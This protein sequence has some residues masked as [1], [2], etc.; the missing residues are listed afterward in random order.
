MAWFVPTDQLDEI[1][2]EGRKGIS[3]LDLDAE[4][5]R[6]GAGTVGGVGRP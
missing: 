3:R 2:L 1:V 5:E 4:V 6:Y